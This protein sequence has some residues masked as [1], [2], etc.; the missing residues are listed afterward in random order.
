MHSLCSSIFRLGK[1][2]SFHVCYMPKTM[3]I[4][5]CDCIRTK[6]NC[7]Q[8]ATHLLRDKEQ[9][10]FNALLNKMTLSDEQENQV[11]KRNTIPVI[12]TSKS[13]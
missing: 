8:L 11:Q 5:I 4:F 10:I 6:H 2:K 7:E 1:K 13:L 12:L 3:S 9:W